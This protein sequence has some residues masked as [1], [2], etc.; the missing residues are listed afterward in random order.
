MMLIRPLNFLVLPLCSPRLSGYSCQQLSNPGDTEKHG[1]LHRESQV[2]MPTH[3]S[4]ILNQHNVSCHGNTVYR[5]RTIARDG[6]IA[7]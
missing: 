6:E 1:G 7:Y 5:N 2:R 3:L 4:E